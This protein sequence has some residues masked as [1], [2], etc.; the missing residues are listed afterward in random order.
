MK[1]KGKR[2]ITVLISAAVLLLAV[3]FVPN[4]IDVGKV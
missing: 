3:I 1:R 4:F 2:I